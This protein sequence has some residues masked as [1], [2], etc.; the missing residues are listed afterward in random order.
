[1]L[2]R[3]LPVAFA[4]VLGAL[5]PADAANTYTYSNYTVVDPTDANVGVY[6]NNNLIGAGGAGQVVLAGAGGNTGSTQLTWCIDLIDELEPYGNATGPFTVT[7]GSPV[8]Y[9]PPVVAGETALAALTAQQIS[10]MGGLMIY[11]DANI[12]ATN[13]SPAAQ[14]A[15]WSIE[16]GSHYQFAAYIGNTADTAVDSLAVTLVTDAKNGTIPGYSAWETLSLTDSQE[17]GAVPEPASIA[18]LGAGLTGLYGIRRRR[19]RADVR[20]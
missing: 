19:V 11:G 1:M 10:E 2:S 5:T 15:I 7:T 18:L 12:S 17:L 4:L 3:T 6:Y 20:G 14:I 8:G 9:E 16:Y 13:V